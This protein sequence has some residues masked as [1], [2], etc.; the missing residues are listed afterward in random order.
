MARARS[1]DR[2]NAGESWVKRRGH[3]SRLTPGLKFIIAAHKP[4]E[5]QFEGVAGSATLSVG[6]M[7]RSD[8][9]EQR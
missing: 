2:A 1:A 9:E 6:K 4:E 5:R 8:D 3:D 7:E